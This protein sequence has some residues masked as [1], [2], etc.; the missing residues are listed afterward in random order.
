MSE[1]LQLPGDA[2]PPDDSATSSRVALWRAR[3]EQ[4]ADRYQARAQRQPLLGLPL[5]FLARYTAR[6]GM[7]LASAVAFRL[8]LWL[9]PLALLSAGIFAAVAENSA[10]SLES[11]SK[12]AGL[13]GAAS[14]QVVTQLQNGHRSWFIAVVTG[15]VLFLW[16]T[17][18]LIRTLTVATAHAWAAPVPRARQKDR[19]ITTFMFAGGWI[20]LFVFTSLVSHVDR[21]PGGILSDLVINAS[22]T[23]VLWLLI[24]LRL[25]DRRASWVDLLPGCVLLGVGFAVMNVVSRV[26]LPVRFAHSSQIYGTL[27]VAAVILAWLLLVGQLIVS[28]ALI[29]AVWSAYISDRRSGQSP[30]TQRDARA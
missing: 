17:R 28:S 25:P 11:A 20:A 3:A 5:T 8:F 1:P 21:T 16:T 6:Q 29:N 19:L 13:T 7:L 4:A 18:T 23:A 2:L 27:G 9:L 10:T 14:Q 30:S 22:A 12:A 15:A 26:Y 24:C